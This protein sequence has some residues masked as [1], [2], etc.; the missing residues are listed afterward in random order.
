MKKHQKIGSL[1]LLGLVVGLVVV[2][3]AATKRSTTSG[4]LLQRESLATSTNTRSNY[5]RRS[6]LQPRLSWAL[7]Q[8]GD[9]LERPGKERTAAVAT[10]RYE[11]DQAPRP[12][13][14]VSEFPDRLRISLTNA[15]SERTLIFDRDRSHVPSQLTE[16]EEALLETLVYDS[17]E[18]FFSTQAQRQA[19]R[20]IGSR[21]RMDDG[22]NPDYRGPY[23]DVYQLHD[24]IKIGPTEQV[25]SKFYYFNSDTLLLERVLYQTTTQSGSTNVEVLLS[26]WRNVNDQRVPHRIERIENGQSRFVFSLSSLNITPRIDDGA[27]VPAN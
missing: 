4:P 14:L 23:Y 21:I 24:S 22:S 16:N 10:I 3:F 11:T 19:T 9:R 6:I 25:R 17:A 26:E 8:L 5:V 27:F 1:M 7:T 15:G 18:H 2:V 12:V 20:F 13:V